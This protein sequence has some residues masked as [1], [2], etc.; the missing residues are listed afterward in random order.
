MMGC[1][2]STTGLPL[3]KS[4]GYS[5]ID[6]DSVLEEAVGKPIHRV[7]EEE[8]EVGF[9]F[10]E[11]QIISSIGE[12]HSLVVATGGGVVLRSENWGVLHQGVV[13]WLDA[14]R[15]IIL[16]RLKLDPSP[17][18]L[19][20]SSDPSLGLDQLLNDRKRFYEEADLRVS[21]NQE[22]PEEVVQYILDS[23]PPILRDPL[24][25][26]AQQTIAK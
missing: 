5:F 24:D 13:I 10:L 1:G 3:A 26:S 14:S 11:A 18:P 8:G 20:N 17:R 16:E 2:K 9:R 22:P 15:E 21:I 6:A 7:F 25:P 4:I 19:L 23:L 12:R